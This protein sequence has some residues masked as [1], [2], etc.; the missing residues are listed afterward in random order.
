[1][2]AQSSHPL[3]SDPSHLAGPLA[4]ILVPVCGAV[5]VVGAMLLVGTP[6]L[7]V[8]GLLP[9]FTVLQSLIAG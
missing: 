8:A 5:A 6:E 9:D 1:M 3:V 2:K 4:A 7:S